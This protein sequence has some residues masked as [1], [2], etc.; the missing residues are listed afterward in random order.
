MRL[1]RMG[2]LSCGKILGVLYAGLGL[3]LGGVAAL[4]SVLGGLAG[5]A[6]DEGGGALFAV[7]FGVGAVIFLPVF[8]GVIGFIGRVSSVITRPR[9]G[10]GRVQARAP[11]MDRELGGEQRPAVYDER[12]PT[13]CSLERVGC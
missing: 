12:G 4:V 9:T 10:A 13:D 6:A 2:A 8:Y 5:L 11:R 7:F 1:K 3:I